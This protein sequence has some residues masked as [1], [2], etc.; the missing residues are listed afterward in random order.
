MMTLA[1][2]RRPKTANDAKARGPIKHA[3]L[4]QLFW[5][6]GRISE[7]E[8]EETGP[9]GRP[10]EVPLAEQIADMPK[11]RRLAVLA[12]D[13]G[14]AGSAEQLRHRK[15]AGDQEKSEQSA[16]TEQGFG[17]HAVFGLHG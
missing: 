16:E 17:D 15:C 3:R 12:V 5:L 4:E 1:K 13:E 11:Q 14:R 7:F 6:N 8:S 2:R 9:T 10:Q